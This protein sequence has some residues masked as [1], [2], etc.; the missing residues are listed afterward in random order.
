MNAATIAGRTRPI[1]PR[2]PG[3]AK[4]R[5]GSA[6]TVSLIAAAVGLAPTE[7]TMGHA[8]RVLYIHV[9]VAWLGLLGFVV[10]A[11]AGLLYLLRR[12]LEWDRWA[13]ATAELGW[14]CSSLTL[15]T[16]SLW[17]HSAWGAWW[18]WDPRLTTSF[19]L[20][21]IYGGYLVSRESMDDPHRRARLAA[22]LAILGVLD[23]P[24]VVM[25]TRWFRAIHPASP[26]MEPGMR[27]ALVLT[28]L[29][30]AAFVSLL[31][32]C[33]RDQLRLVDDL[34]DLRQIADA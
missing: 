7:A 17:A 21:A 25:A 3:G 30:L 19:V 1:P 26:T 27:L 10:V 8:Q 23:V 13:Q 5:L 34:R 9:S 11:A 16:G 24:L 18:T 14:L 6:A 2:L 15:V 31:V 22:V 29:G 12:D 33:R 20:W 32:V 28:A 4:T